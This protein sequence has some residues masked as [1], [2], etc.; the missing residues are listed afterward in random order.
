MRLGLRKF[1]YVIL[2]SEE[3]LCKNQVAKF[4]GNAA[5]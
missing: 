2:L 3:M 5:I 4:Q 1:E